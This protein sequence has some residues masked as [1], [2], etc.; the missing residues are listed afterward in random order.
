MPQFLVTVKIP[1]A[2]GHNPHNKQTGTCP[3]NPGK[4]CTDITGEHHTILWTDDSIAQAYYHWKDDHG[5]CVTRVEE[6]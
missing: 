2:D 1:K 4:V 3:V 5:M 6:V